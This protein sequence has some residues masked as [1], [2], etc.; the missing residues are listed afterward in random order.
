MCRQPAENG[1]GEREL[2]KGKM[3]EI[4]WSRRYFLSAVR[5]ALILGAVFLAAAVPGRAQAAEDIVGIS[6]QKYTYRELSGDIAELRRRYPKLVRWR[7]VGRSADN[8]RIYEVTIGNPKAKKHLIVF[9]NIHARE[10]MTTQLV[11]RQAEITLRCRSDYV[12][13]TNTKI[14]EVLNQ[15]QIHIFPSINPDGT[16]ISQFGIRAIRN[17]SLRNRLR[18]M[19]G[20]AWPSLWKAN[21]RGV[22]LNRNW[23]SGF[24]RRGTRGWQGYS[25]PRAF[26]EPETQAVRKAVLRIRRSGKLLGILNYHATGSLIYGRSTGAKSI[27]NAIRLSNRMASVARA[28]TGYTMVSSDVNG[29]GGYCLEYWR[30]KMHVP[31]ITLEIGTSPCPLPSSEFMSIWLD[32]YDLVLREAMALGNIS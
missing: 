22:D 17:V 3:T 8:R 25:G 31:T 10:Y 14:G 26:S 13:G 2:R 15:C 32:N 19:P 24:Y 20:S 12:E 27:T 21:A 5:A 23:N 1:A 18:K 7:S 30:F 16:A 9:A 6:H 29:R 28:R 11:M 4:R